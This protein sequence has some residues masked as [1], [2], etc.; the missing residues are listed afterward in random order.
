MV[1][2]AL[3]GEVNRPP[4]EH[5]LTTAMQDLSPRYYLISAYTSPRPCYSLEPSGGWRSPLASPPSPSP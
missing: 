1:G 2:V 3:V 4:H 5:E